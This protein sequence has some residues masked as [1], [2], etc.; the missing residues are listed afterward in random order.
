M[1]MIN[2]ANMVNRTL[3]SYEAQSIY[4]KM[5]FHNKSNRSIKADMISF[6]FMEIV[7]KRN[8]FT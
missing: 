8:H 4:F 2:M 3:H 6:R 7:S 1:M 5:H